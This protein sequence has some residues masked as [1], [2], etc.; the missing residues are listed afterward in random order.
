MWNIPLSLLNPRHSIVEAGKTADQVCLFPVPFR[1]APHSRAPQPL[2]CFRLLGVTFESGQHRTRRSS[3][4]QASYPVW[5]TPLEHMVAWLTKIGPCRTF[6]TGRRMT[7]GRGGICWKA[8]MRRSRA[9][10]TTPCP[11][12]CLNL[13]PSSLNPRGGR[14]GVCW[15]VTM[16]SRRGQVRTLA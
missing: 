6:R 7:G 9:Q 15:R 10:V 3:R 1:P 2:N 5:N 4:A 12:Q 14:G 11:A 16:R 13:A 8:T